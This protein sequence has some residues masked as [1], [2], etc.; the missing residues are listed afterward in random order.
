MTPRF[1]SLKEPVTEAIYNKIAKVVDSRRQVTLWTNLLAFCCR[2]NASELFLKV[3]PQ[4]APVS[5][6][7]VTLAKDF[8]SKTLLQVAAEEGGIAVVKKL[9]GRLADYSRSFWNKAAE[10]TMKPTQSRNAE[11]RQYLEKYAKL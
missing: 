10:G 3:L 4:V 5:Y 11:V 1:E 9:D 7:N 8:E 6:Y 2:Y